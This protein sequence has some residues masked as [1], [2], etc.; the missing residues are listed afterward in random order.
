MWFAFGLPS[1]QFTAGVGRSGK[2][3]DEECW[4][5]LCYVLY[6]LWEIWKERNAWVFK[7]EM[8]SI[9]VIFKRIKMQVSERLLVDSIERGAGFSDVQLFCWSPLFGMRKLKIEE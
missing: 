3:G 9:V 6:T 1:V 8:S 5:K 2:L 7:G 4:R